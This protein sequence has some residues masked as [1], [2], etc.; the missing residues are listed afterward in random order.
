MSLTLQIIMQMGLLGLALAI[1]RVLERNHINWLS[2][3]GGAL[4][5][6]MV[7]GLIVTLA[8]N[9]SYNYTVLFQFN[10]RS[11]QLGSLRA[12]M[13][14]VVLPGQLLLLDGCLV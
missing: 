4:I 1:G 12:V 11:C 8:K 2:E 9:L 3:A 14:I 10:V 5:V 13:A 6:G 7:I